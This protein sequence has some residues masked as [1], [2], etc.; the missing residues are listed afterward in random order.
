VTYLTPTEVSNIITLFSE[1]GDITIGD[2][3]HTL[4]EAQVKNVKFTLKID[5]CF[6]GWFARYL[7]FI[8]N[9]TPGQPKPNS[10]LALVEASSSASELSFFHLSDP[11]VLEGGNEVKKHTTTT[12]P[13]G[14]SEATNGNL[15]GLTA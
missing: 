9:I 8:R 5:S 12:N 13:N 7:L 4:T 14:L 1:P 3:T 11:V 2:K 6:S 15:Y 10:A